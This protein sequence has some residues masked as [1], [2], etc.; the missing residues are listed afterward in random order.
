MACPEAVRA[1]LAV[2]RQDEAREWAANALGY[3]E[4]WGVPA[5][6]GHVLRG[7]AATR[8]AAEGIEVLE[9][10]VELASISPS[11]LQLGQAHSL[12]DLGVVLRRNGHRADAREPLRQAFDIARRCGAV[13]IARRAHEELQAT[14][15]K[16][17]R[18]TPI[19]VE[20]L[21]PSERR[22]AELAASGMT[23]RQIAQSLFVTVKT[24][25]AHLSAAYDKLDIGSRK[26][27]P[28][29]LGAARPE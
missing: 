4:Q 29:A 13:R 24:V 2:G 11:Q 28:G 15:E 21:T 25:E 5:G 22:V 3:A 6:V 10:S 19:G 1:L 23:N 27:L 7:V 17:R 14:G 12:L 18:Y 26:Q 8:P 16:V 20:S 9:R